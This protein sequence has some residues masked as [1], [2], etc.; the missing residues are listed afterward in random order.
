MSPPS[1]R[2]NARRGR[3]GGAQ[4]QARDQSCP[5][6]AGEGLESR[7]GTY[8]GGASE[9]C[10]AAQLGS[11]GSAVTRARSHG[12]AV[13]DGVSRSSKGESAKVLHGGCRVRRGPSSSQLTHVSSAE[14]LQH[15]GDA[16]GAKVRSL[17]GSAGFPDASESEGLGSETYRRRKKVFSA[18]EMD[19]DDDD[20]ERSTDE[21]EDEEEEENKT[22]FSRAYARWQKCLPQCRVSVLAVFAV[23]IVASILLPGTFSLVP[24]TLSARKL[25]RETEVVQDTN[26][27]REIAALISQRLVMT[28]STALAQKQAF[29]GGLYD[30]TNITTMLFF[31]HDMLDHYTSSSSLFHVRP[32]GAFYGI[33][34]DRVGGYVMQYWFEN[35]TLCEMGI[36]PATMK[37]N[38]PATH[39]MDNYNASHLDWY[40][41]FRY[42][43]VAVNMSWTHLYK[44]MDVYVSFIVVAWGRN[45]T[46]M[47]SFGCDLLIGSVDP[48]VNNTL[49]NS[50]MLFFVEVDTGALIYASDPSVP[51][52]AQSQG[53]NSKA[54]MYRVHEV[55]N[56]WI[57]AADKAVSENGLT[58]PQVG[59]TTLWAEGNILV[60]IVTIRRTGLA[61]AIVSVNECHIVA[62]TTHTVVTLVVLV[63]IC[64]GAGMW[65]MTWSLCPLSTLSKRMTAITKLDF[66]DEAKNKLS[67][68]AEM[69]KMQLSFLSL[70]SGIIALTRYVSPVI[71]RDV[72]DRGPEAVNTE[73]KPAHLAVLYTDLRGFTTLSEEM[74]HEALMAVLNKW[75]C[76]FGAVIRAH[77]GTIDKFIGDCIMTIFGAPEPLT[78]PEL[79]ACQTAL[80]FREALQRVNT[81]AHEVVKINKKY[82]V[83][84]RVGIDAGTLLVGNIGFSE[85]MNY[86]VCGDAAHI[87]S[88]LEQLGK[89][90]LLTPLIS[91]SVRN[92]VH[93]ELIC[94]FVDLV[95]VPGTNGSPKS[96]T[97]YHIMCA[98]AEA[99]PAQLRIKRVFSAIHRAFINNDSATVLRL[100][101]YAFHHHNYDQ[102]HTVLRKIEQRVQNALAADDDIR[103][104]VQEP[105]VLMSS[106]IH[107]SD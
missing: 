37:P 64:I 21:E 96:V 1:A 74:S 65:I 81:Y 36:D 75:F 13:Q 86:T 84:Y 100:V 103:S 69:Q 18:Q 58:W 73:M 20:G 45:S 88:K 78:D 77:G 9:A 99:T 42:G 90:Y 47:G 49:A 107:I 52:G 61:W 17:P 60:S 19:D 26:V 48:L 89:E 14:Q 41:P 94:T 104:P 80:C 106:H 27:V 87:A 53:R 29:V 85:H 95:T 72:M 24:M 51:V 30:T 101:S 2:R 12:V 105:S 11:I 67:P 57:R 102:Y 70:R 55:A 6:I 25:L 62:V 92:K 39:C 23:L 34:R 97:V 22:F 16:S 5:C 46:N 15:R 33:L 8:S 83:D 10:G 98:R 54:E 4:H 31:F 35:E 79:R 71:V 63:C 56:K 32:N 91:Q 93:R 3:Q 44:S 40:A 68:A 28:E 66:T 76:E 38:G 43:H 50:D 82:T 7:S 59:N